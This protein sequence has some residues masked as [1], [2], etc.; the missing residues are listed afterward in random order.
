MAIAGL[1]AGAVAQGCGSDSVPLVT[2]SSTR[3]GTIAFAYLRATDALDHPPRNK[4]E[5]APFLK[6]EPDAGDPDKPVSE[7]DLDELFRSPTDGQDYVI[8]WG[9]DFRDLGLSRRKMP[10]LGYEKE[11]KDGKRLVAQGRYVHIVT[12]EQ[13]ADL[14]FPPGFRA[15]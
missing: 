10:V 8:L 1:L 4:D 12:D 9:A 14:P 13:L 11:S 15:P 2:S 3:L 5:L 7:I 6:R